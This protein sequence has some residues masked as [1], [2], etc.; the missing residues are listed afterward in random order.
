MASN[1]LGSRVIC[2]T[3]TNFSM[4]IS[5]PSYVAYSNRLNVPS[6]CAPLPRK[7]SPHRKI[8]LR[9]PKHPPVCQPLRAMRHL[10]Q[11]QPRPHRH[12]QYRLLLL[13]LLLLRLLTREQLTQSV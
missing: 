4:P 3:P 11:P 8:R 5:R 13:L 2:R 10:L 7:S 12:P 9:Q 1:P 6:R